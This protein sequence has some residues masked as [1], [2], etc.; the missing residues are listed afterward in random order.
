[1]AIAGFVI[2]IISAIAYF[3]LPG[4]ITSIIGLGIS[5]RAYKKNLGSQK[6]AK[7]GILLNGFWLI[8]GIVG[9]F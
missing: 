6:L 2:G 5:Y 3:G 1:M 9:E 7:I 8:F 4:I